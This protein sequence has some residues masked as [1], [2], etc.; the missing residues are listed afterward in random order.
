MKLRTLKDLLGHEIQDLYSAETQLIEALP[1]M[2]NAA[3]DSS[4]KKAFEQHLAETK[5]QRDRL[6]KVAKHL[7]ISP[8]G[9]TC[10]A[11][12]GLVKEGQ[13]MIH[14]DAAES[15]K[16]AGLIAS[17][18]RIEH[19]EIAGYGT[20]LQFAKQLDL[21]DIEALLSETLEE[22]KD[23]N[24]KLNDLAIESINKKAMA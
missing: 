16:D 2:A 4:L 13:H 21:S 20:A 10:K 5:K 12:A 6:A 11:M 1:K 9:T 23:T 18:Q 22:E 15:V 17:A 3:H 14:E 8:E 7:G 19:Y 24:E